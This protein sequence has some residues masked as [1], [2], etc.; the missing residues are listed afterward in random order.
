MIRM[1]LDKEAVSPAFPASVSLSEQTKARPLRQKN[2]LPLPGNS[3]AA[4]ATQRIAKRRYSTG[5]GLTG[6]AKRRRRANS[7]SQSEPVLPSHFLLGGNIFDPLNLNSLLDEDVNRA[8]NQETPKCSPLPARGGDPVEILVPRDITDPLNL[9]G[10][11]RDGEGGAKV[12]L[13]PL[14]SRRRHRNRH[15]GGGGGAEKGA[16]PARLFPATAPPTEGAVSPLPCELN[17][18]ITC[19]DDVAPPPILPRR[20]THP[21]LGA[22]HR[23]GNQ[24]DGRQRRRRRTT[25]MRKDKLRFQFGNHSG[26]YGY[27]GS[28]GDAWEGRVG[29][30]EDPRLRLLEADWFR[31]R[32]VLDVGCGAGH[33]A[34]AVARRFNPAHILGVELDPRLAHAA[35]QNIRHF[36]SHDLATTGGCQGAL[37]PPLPLSFRVSRGP[38]AAPPLFL[39][40]TSSSSSSSRFPSNVTF[41]QGDYVSEAWPGRGQYDV[42]MCLSVTKWVQLQS[43]DGGVARLFRRAYQSLAPGGLFI[44][45]PQPWSSYAHSKRI[46]EWTY[47]NFRAVRL[48]PEQFTSYLTDSVGFSSYRLLTHTDRSILFIYL[49][50]RQVY[51]IYISWCETGLYYNIL[52]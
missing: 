10:G 28:Y 9:K 39:P 36:L 34:L 25:S 11:G 51:I 30:A 24:G 32:T 21:P 12:L 29:A 50:V 35:T 14:K 1:S 49:G 3:Q 8:T 17:T 26:Y 4:P 19:R 45:E 40:L 5:A 20:H 6:A 22:A 31:D 33:L 15:H 2:G 13:S 16:E 47:R 37:A 48:R 42:I 43:G 23:P 7:D 18:A 46:S 38:L 44:L 27:Q 52:V 41:I